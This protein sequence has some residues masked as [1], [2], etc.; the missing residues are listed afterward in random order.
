[1]VDQVTHIM[2]ATDG[3]GGARRAVEVASELAKALACDLLIATVANHL[4]GEEVRQLAH[5]PISAGD[6]L[7]AMTDQTLRA[8]EGRARE[9]GV[10]RVEI[11]TAWGDVAQSLLDIAAGSSAKM[12]GAVAAHW[13]ACC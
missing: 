7:K 3:S 9:L 1:M 10:L 6:L 12:I 5:G 2:V 11:Q 13:P 4:L 8:A